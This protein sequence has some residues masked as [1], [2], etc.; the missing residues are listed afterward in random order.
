MYRILLITGNTKESLTPA[1]K[2]LFVHCKEALGI[3]DIQ[4]IRQHHKLVWWWWNPTASATMHSWWL[5]LISLW[6]VKT[7]MAAC[8]SG[9]IHTGLKSREAIWGESH[10]TVSATLLVW[11]TKLIGCNWLLVLHSQLELRVQLLWSD[12]SDMQIYWNLKSL[13]L[14]MSQMQR[15][16]AASSDY[17]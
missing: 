9:V 6:C 14:Y 3:S 10:R 11:R 7:C 16:W 8:L 5:H 2:L 13:F 1:H 15:V 4:L 12:H 17:E